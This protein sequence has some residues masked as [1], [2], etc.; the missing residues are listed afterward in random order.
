MPNQIQRMG[1]AEWAMLLL[2]S[3]IWGGSFFLVQV[4]VAELPPIVLVAARV[5]L[6]AAALWAVVL[7]GRLPVPRGRPV[8]RGLLVLGMMN[9]VLPFFLLAWGQSRVTSGLAAVLNATTPLWGVLFAAVLT[10]D[11][12]ATPGRLGGVAIGVVGVGFIMGPAVL[13]GETPAELPVLPALAC[14]GAAISY[15]YAGVFGRRFAGLPPLVVAAGQLGCASLVALPLAA[16]AALPAGLPVPSL[17]TSL[18]VLALALVCSAFAYV[19]YFRI[20]RAA[21]ATSVLLVTQLV[22]VT[23][24]LLGAIFLGEQ[25]SSRVFAGMALIALGLAIVDG[26]VLRLVRWRGRAPKRR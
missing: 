13:G 5:G 3:V 10:R 1:A 15:G 26:R 25:V 17:R 23:A 14:V 24:I 4:I 8:W 6:A 12:R 9:N 16:A 11:E 19:L 2:L 20:L 18:A 7:V 21:G 22:P